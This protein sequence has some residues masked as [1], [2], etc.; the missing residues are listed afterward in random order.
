MGILTINPPERFCRLQ[1]IQNRCSRFFYVLKQKNRKRGTRWLCSE[2]P[3]P[4][5]SFFSR[6]CF[7]INWVVQLELTSTIY[8]KKFWMLEENKCMF[9]I[10]IGKNF[11]L[12]NLHNSLQSKLKKKIF[13]LTF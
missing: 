3:P 13:T 7:K 5:L 11:C 1:T 8:V 10:L 4:R 9:V 2:E 12:K 6:Y